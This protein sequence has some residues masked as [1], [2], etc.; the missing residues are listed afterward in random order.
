[1]YGYSHLILIADYWNG[2]ISKFFLKLQPATVDHEAAARR[3]LQ[4]HSGFFGQ[5]IRTGKA[6]DALILKPSSFCIAGL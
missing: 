5:T 2:S 3:I 1:V 6:P 4:N